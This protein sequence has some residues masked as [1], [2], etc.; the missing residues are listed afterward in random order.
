MRPRQMLQRHDVIGQPGSAIA[1]PCGGTT[2]PHLFGIVMA[3]ASPLS[4]SSFQ[5][6]L[7]SPPRAPRSCLRRPTIS[8]PGGLNAG[9]AGGLVDRGRGAPAGRSARCAAAAR[10]R[11]GLSHAGKTVFLTALL[12][13][14]QLAARLGEGQAE[15]LP[16]FDPVAKG[17]ARGRRRCAPLARPA[18]LSVRAQ[19]RASWPAR[20]RIARL[21][22]EHDRRLRLRCRAALS[23]ARPARPTARRTPRRSTIEI[24]DYPGEWLLDL[25]CS[26]RATTSGRRRRSGSPTAARAHRSPAPGATSRRCAGDR[27]HCSKS[28]RLSF[29]GYLARLPRARRYHLSL[30]QPGPLPRPGDGRRTSRPSAS[31]RCGPPGGGVR[32]GSLAAS[33]ARPLRALQGGDRSARSTGRVQPLR[34]P[35][36][37]GRCRRRAQCRAAVVP[38]HAPAPC[39]TVLPSFKRD[40][41]S[42]LARLFQLAHR[43]GAVRRHE[44]RPR[45]RQPVPQ[46]A[47]AAARHDGRRCRRAADR[48]RRDGIRRA[49]GVKC[50]ANRRVMYQGQ[51]IT[52]LEGVIRGRDAPEQLYPGEIPEHLPTAGGLGA[53]SASAS[54]ISVR[55]IWR[56]NRLMPTAAAFPMCI[57]TAPCNS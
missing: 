11:H 12:H 4:C 54:T 19:L 18:A 16:F 45:H 40:G 41:D 30:V 46:S 53:R 24:I 38:R 57:W 22:A 35:A 20:W 34:S 15:H 55:P 37:A 17:S 9:A 26:N 1:E 32:P 2:D 56:T 10:R 36:R 28:A 39:A 31:A 42:L 50:T 21:P 3:A 6:L 13:N 43:E 8:G 33:D 23:A 48:R 14:L 47:P 49:V 44:G 29:T 51:Q 7:P 27:G 52:V 25:P 5:T